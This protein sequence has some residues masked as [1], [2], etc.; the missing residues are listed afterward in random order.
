MFY[1]FKGVHFP[2]FQTI[3]PIPPILY[4]LPPGFFIL[5]DN[6]LI[7]SLPKLMIGLDVS[8]KSYEIHGLGQDNRHVFFLPMEIRLAHFNDSLVFL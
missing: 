2:L 3:P 4:S 1:S 7:L 5:P 6:S 8:Q